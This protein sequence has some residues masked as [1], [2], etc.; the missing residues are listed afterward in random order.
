MGMFSR[1]KKA[2][3][4]EEA[5]EEE[6][7]EDE[8]EAPTK[9]ADK[10]SGGG[11]VEKAGNEYDLDVEADGDDPAT[12][13]TVVA[14]LY[15]KYKKNYNRRTDYVALFSFLV[16]VSFYLSIL[17]LQRSA[18]EAYMLTST[19]K[20]ALIPEDSEMGSSQDVR[21]WIEDVVTTTWTDARCGDGRC[22]APF[23][24]PEY[25]R[26]GCKADC[27]LLTLKA[28]ITKIQI[29][30]YY[31]FS[32]PKGSV[33]PID[34]MQDAKWNLCPMEVD[35][36]IGPKKIFHGADC[37]YEED[38]GFEDQVGHKVFEIDDIPDGEWSIVVKKDIFL[39][40][41]GAVRPR[42]NVTL[43]ATNK[44]LLLAA[45]Y[46]QVRRK[47]E[48]TEYNKLLST[49]TKTNLTL[50]NAIL[51][52]A[53]MKENGTV[54]AARAAKTLPEA[55]YTASI[56]LIQN[57]YK[58]NRTMATVALT[59]GGY[60]QSNF[61]SLL[62]G[63]T[64]YNTTGKEPLSKACKCE[65]PG[66][67]GT[68]NGSLPIFVSSGP[69][70]CKCYESVD[71]AC[72]ETMRWIMIEWRRHLGQAWTVKAALRDAVT[73]A[74]D[75]EM[76]T[77]LDWL[78]SLS[79]VTFFEI[80]QI[81]GTDPEKLAEASLAA[82]QADNINKERA[83]DPSYTALV[84]ATQTNFPRVEQLRSFVTARATTLSNV[85]LS[86]PIYI[87]PPI[88]PFNFT[89]YNK[90]AVQMIMPLYP[91]YPLELDLK[92]DLVEWNPAVLERQDFAFMTCNLDARAPIFDG[93][94]LKPAD[95]VA[96]LVADP[97][98]G[99]MTPY[100]RQARFQKLCDA[101][102][103]CDKI[104]CPTGSY[105]SCEI[106]RRTQQFDTV[107]YPNS[108][109]TGRK[110]LGW[111][112]PPSDFT[113]P[114]RRHLLQTGSATDLDTI[115]TAVKDLSSKQASL[116]TKIEGV[117]KAQEVQNSAAEEHHK[118]KALEN[119]IKAGFDDL[120]KGHESLSK[121]LEEILAKQQ[122]A[123]AAAQESLRIQQRTNALAEAGLR[124]IERL[125]KAVEK[126]RESI[127]AAYASGAFAN[128]EQYIAI[129]ENAVVTREIKAK[130]NLLMNTP[131]QMKVLYNSFELANFNN[132]EPPIAYRERF[133]GL[134]NR[135]IAGMLIYIE[136]KNL[137]ECESN[138]FEGIDRTCS[139]GRDISSFGV[140][141]VFKLGTPL[142]NP[143]YD[144]FET[145]T[146]V[147]NCTEFANPDAGL[148]PTYNMSN[149]SNGNKP[150]FCMELY[151]PRDIPY[152]FRH[153]SIPGYSD[154]FPY[155]FDI[156]LSADEAQRWIDF[157]T[158]GLM[159]DDVKTEKVTAQIVVY[160]AELGYFG[161]VMVFFEF[162]EGG[163]IEVSHSVNTIKVELYETTDDW[164][165]FAMEI[166]LTIGAVHSVYSEILDLVES[167]RTRG[168]YLAYFSSMWNYI[169]VASIT[170]HIGTIFM[171]FTFG[172]KMAAEF[173][174]DIHYDI[175]KNLEASAFITNLKV[176][177]QMSEMGALF[178]EMK[179]LVTYLQLYMTL[180]GINIILMLARIL[181]LMD[182][183][184]RL[185][186]ITH[187][188]ALATADLMH[189][190]VIFFMIFMGYA[191]IGH[192][193]FG[194]AS[195]HFSDMTASVNSLF[196]NLL[197]D[198]TYFMED[199]KSANGLTFI[200]GMIYFYSFNIFVLMILFNFLLAIICDAFGE[201]KANASESVSVVTELVPMI[202]DKWRTVFSR[203]AYPDHIPESRVR[204]QL[205]IWKGENP[206]EEEDD[207]VEEAPDKVFKYSDA[208]ELDLPGLK[209]VLR[210]CVI[211]T[212]Q[213]NDAKFL[214]RPTSKEKRIDD[215]AADIAAEE[216]GG[217]GGG[218]KG[219]FSRRASRS[220]RKEALATAE[221]IEAAAEMLMEQV[222]EEPEADGDEEDGPTE[223]EQLQESL[224][225]LLKAQQKLVEGQVKVIEGQAKMADRQDRLS[226]LE[227]RILNVLEQPPPS[228][229]GAGMGGMLSA[230]KK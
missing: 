206:D 111:D 2:E 4:E 116:D 30:I 202:T 40:V 69:S 151:N 145:L 93:K 89:T 88:Y 65:T 97:G 106:C 95:V 156:N 132:T 80:N 113:L 183:Q 148:Y 39:K 52:A 67:W 184:P 103:Y 105:C 125:A 74:A 208:K 112:N 21:D 159:I 158:Y 169:D 119:I 38:N 144:N 164:V 23:E 36:L 180:S 56:T 98:T 162:T 220:K 53:E 178:L 114:Y 92:L 13:A 127:Q 217:G 196:Q 32:H 195:V 207:E 230:L 120:K 215:I 34:L 160:N 177:N 181:K 62:N 72:S 81:K 173:S 82:L 19:L 193:I 152:G 171:W 198:I 12:A 154:G 205:R 54:I 170:I 37:Y 101:V 155:F 229:G 31:N 63:T 107:V 218:I 211:E 134:N 128:I 35:E 192:V 108:T 149:A 117:K 11:G 3:P 10:G 131:C 102:C 225:K 176:P 222:G 167:K 168:S 174:P 199:F 216:E 90:A 16:F 124:Q 136:R 191:F 49:L 150:P 84:A 75:K 58:L 179:D 201:V 25:G 57:K 212:Y 175:Y 204:R 71:I 135:V 86:T 121:S 28:K 224:E 140:D 68:V 91:G 61:V 122:Q 147:Y 223:V 163:K 115:L 50:A 143:D 185:G 153:K 100:L 139:G 22:E 66:S 79:P 45:H 227:K 165:R 76:A 186:V 190:F 55:N 78:S 24:F 172:W 15:A 130:E 6:E 129:Q 219:F 203:V 73:I 194:Y 43:E 99:S 87:S 96:P 104:G 47:M 210:R 14:A 123:L 26:F 188:L 85:S 109:V 5:E 141:P 226:E 60:C 182:F 51:D 64:W 138:R 83:K 133:I 146:K 70:V 221:E 197:G 189:F 200:V 214:L 209:R 118:D 20:S 27:D 33:S 161:N 1:K 7:E 110:L 166:L 77:L 94:C 213:R 41:A 48:L 46:G 157:M 44:R 228:S 8:D 187:T 59:P 42:I 142:Y 137:V 29:D 17:Y 9:G 18:E 126:Q